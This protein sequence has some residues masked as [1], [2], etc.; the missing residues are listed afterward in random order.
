MNATHNET[1]IVSVY[2]CRNF[3]ELTWQGAILRFKPFR[4]TWN[5][6]TSN[7]K[8]DGMINYIFHIATGIASLGNKI[9]EMTNDHE[10][11]NYLSTVN[12]L[13]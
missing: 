10:Q 12:F 7:I 11:D 9:S 8:I 5:E 1:E 2:S 6:R 13:N 4:D 3:F